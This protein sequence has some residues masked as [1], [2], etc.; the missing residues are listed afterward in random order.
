MNPDPVQLHI[1]SVH[2]VNLRDIQSPMHKFIIVDVLFVDTHAC[3][4]C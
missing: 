1:Y 3:I 2:L 4:I